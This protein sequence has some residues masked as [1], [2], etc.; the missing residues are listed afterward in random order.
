MSYTAKRV[1]GSYEIKLNAAFE[2]VRFKF[3]DFT[4]VRSGKP[5]EHDASIIQLFVSATF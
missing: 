3:A 5:Y 4:D 1:P 2:M